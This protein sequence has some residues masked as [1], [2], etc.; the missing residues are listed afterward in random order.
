MGEPDRRSPAPRRRPGGV[1]PPGRC[2]RTRR[3]RRPSADADV[4]IDFDA[5]VGRIRAAGRLA[6]RE[7]IGPEAARRIGC[8]SATLPAVL[9]AAGQPLNIRRATRRIPPGG[10]GA[11][12]LRD[13]ACAMPGCDRPGAWCDGH[14]LVHWADG[15]DTALPSSS[16]ASTTSKP[17][18]DG[19][20]LPVPTSS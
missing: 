8:D 9:G 6:G 20:S 1:G 2:R 11:L 15:G 3:R 7:P 17:R 12:T 19:R 13:E 14:H 5:L 16:I 4:T 18:V 10:P